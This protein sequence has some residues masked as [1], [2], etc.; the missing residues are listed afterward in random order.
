M[1]FRSDGGLVCD[2][3]RI[4]LGQTPINRNEFILLNNLIYSKSEDI[5]YIKVRDSVNV[6]KLLT[7]SL[8]FFKKSFEIDSLNSEKWLERLNFI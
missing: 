3:C 1:L 7:I 4:G 8:D 2:E 6:K 5:K